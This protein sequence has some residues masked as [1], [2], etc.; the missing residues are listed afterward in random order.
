MERL[1]GRA[2]MDEWRE[3]SKRLG[4][5]AE[6][7]ETQRAQRRVELFGEEAGLGGGGHGGF[8]AGDADDAEDGDFR[9]GGA[10]DED[11]V[12]SG[13][14]VGRGDLQAVVEE[15][16]K[17]VGDD[18]FEGV[19][20]GVAEANPEAIEL[21]AAEKR[22]ALGLEIV[23]ELADEVDGADAGQR[24]GLVLTVGGEQIDGVRLTKARG[25]EIAA[26]GLAVR[27]H[28][29]NLL[30]RRGWGPRLQ[31]GGRSDCKAPNLRIGESYV[32]LSTVFVSTPY[33][34]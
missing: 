22:F 11:A 33:F 25:A 27:Q 8:A 5:N 14:Q 24:D 30:V 17:V 9:E 26:D 23:G 20:V 32:M 21:G 29:N 28:H 2:M 12:G 4:I 18:A 31:D 13:V 7:A 15:R 10:R 34:C 1:L 19:A 16:E 3:K 6:I